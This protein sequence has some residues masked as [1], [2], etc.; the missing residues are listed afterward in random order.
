MFI[1]FEMEW[2]RI[3]SATYGKSYELKANELFVLNADCCSNGSNLTNYSSLVFY[4][5]N[6]L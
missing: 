1:L 2:R 3:I 6:F 4:R 5:W